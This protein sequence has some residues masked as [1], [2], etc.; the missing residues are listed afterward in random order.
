MINGDDIMIY[1]FANDYS[2]GAHPKVLETLVNLKEQN[3]GYGLDKHSKNVQ[4]LIRKLTK[5]NRLHTHILPGGTIVNLTF[6]AA[7]LR[8]FEAVISPDTGHIAVHETGAIEATGHKIIACPSTNGK[9]DAETIEKVVLEHTDEHMVKPK[10][11]F[12]S[13]ATEV[14]TIYYKDELIKIREICDK[15]QLLLYLDG[16][17]LANALVA[18]DNDLDL[19]TIA[20]LCDAFYLGG[21]KNGLL[22]GEI[23]VI[24]NP[25]LNEDFRFMIKQR[26]GLSAKGFVAAVQFEAFLKDDLYLDLA[27]NA[28]EMAQKLQKGLLAKNLEMAYPSSTNQIFPILS[29]ELIAKLQK[30]FLFN[31][32]EKKPNNKHVVRFVCSWATKEKAVEALLKEIS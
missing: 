7:V 9:L 26:G 31:I 12:I 17:R 22:F 20:E 13:S 19:V 23:L 6:I 29:D 32:Q 28:N 27:R 2:E 3:K 21:T 1:S 14:G 18:E 16:A 30:K 8:P 10:M 25:K 5:N 4:T 11:V 15:Y 24:I